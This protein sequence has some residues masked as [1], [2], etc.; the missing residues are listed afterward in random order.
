LLYYDYPLYNGT[1]TSLK[2]AVGR[3]MNP[4]ILSKSSGNN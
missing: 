4:E 2:I 1:K 3:N